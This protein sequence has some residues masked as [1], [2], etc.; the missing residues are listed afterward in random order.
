MIAGLPMTG[1]GGI[2]YLLLALAMPFVELSRLLRGE[3]TWAAWRLIG[4]QWLIQTGVFGTLT[5]Q[6]ILISQLMPSAAVKGTR[7]LELAGMQQLSDS[8]TGGLLAGSTLVACLT[9]GIVYLVVQTARVYCTVR[10][11]SAAR[12]LAAA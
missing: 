11:T 1:I 3:S 7:A 2:F 10:R 5:V 9:L 12:A 4:R 8:H 6:A